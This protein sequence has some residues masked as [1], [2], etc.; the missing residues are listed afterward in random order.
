LNLKPKL[1]LAV[2]GR[3]PNMERRCSAT[4][5]PQL[6]SESIRIDLIIK[7][8][9]ATPRAGHDSPK[10]GRSRSLQTNRQIAILT[11]K[12]Q[13]RMRMERRLSGIWTRDIIPYPGMHTGRGE[14]MIRSGAGSLFRKL[15]RRKPFKRQ[16]SGSSS[17]PSKKRST[18]AV[19][20]STV[21]HVFGEKEHAFHAA[22]TQT[23]EGDED[24][25]SFNTSGGVSPH[26][27]RFAESCKGYLMLP[28]HEDGRLRENKPGIR[29]RL[30][31]SLFK[32]LPAH[33]TASRAVP[34][35]F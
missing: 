5:V 11:P 32:G 9:E 23:R 12:R 27:V 19:T 21:D 16:G 6:N 1:S 30:S 13:D 18:Q 22:V 31:L 7:G 14:L 24:K 8:T 2:E 3:R 17:I 10:L 25:D 26:S 33:S 34:V 35:G 28:D 20:V 29:K 15:S 4:S